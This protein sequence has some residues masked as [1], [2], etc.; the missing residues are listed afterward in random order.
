MIL[1]ILE[2]ILGDS[3][4]EAL[5]VNQVLL[6]QPLL[7]HVYK[8]TFRKIKYALIV[9][10]LFTCCFALWATILGVGLQAF[11]LWVE[12]IVIL[13]LRKFFLNTRAKREL[14]KMR[15]SVNNVNPYITYEFGEKIHSIACNKGESFFDYTQITHMYETQ[16]YFILVVEKMICII[17]VKN[18]FSVGNFVDFRKFILEKC[19]FARFIA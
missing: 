5:Y 2:R 17:V 4:M 7:F 15:L 6:S 11:L 9:L 16:D 14:K 3:F 18:N 19:T 12:A 13:S 1:K 10:G 8:T